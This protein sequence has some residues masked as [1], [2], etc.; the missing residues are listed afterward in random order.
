VKQEGGKREGVN[1]EAVA[2][3]VDGVDGCGAAKP[4]AAARALQVR[5]P[6][7]DAKP[8]K[9]SPS[10][11]AAG[12]AGAP[13]APAPASVAAA[14]AKTAS[15]AA[16]ATAA[17]GRGKQV[18]EQAPHSS[19][20]LEAARMPGVA[21]AAPPLPPQA[22]LLPAGASGRAD[23]A[24]AAAL[25]D[26]TSPVQPLPASA[27]VASR[28][29]VLLPGPVRFV[30]ASPQ[31]LV[32]FASATHP[33]QQ[34]PA[35]ANPLLLPH[36]EL[37]GPP[38][39]ADGASAGVLLAVQEAA[40]GAPTWPTSSAIA[41]VSGLSSEPVQ[42]G[43]NAAAQPG[44]LLQQQQQQQQKQAKGAQA[45]A[46][47][48]PR[49]A[50]A[51]AAA[52]GGTLR[53]AS[54]PFDGLDAALP[55]EQRAERAARRSAV[56]EMRLIAVEANRGLHQPGRNLAGTLVEAA[57]AVEEQEA[58]GALQDLPRLTINTGRGEPAA[59]AAAVAAA[60]PTA[61]ADPGLQVNGS[62]ASPFASPS[63]RSPGSARPAHRQRK[64]PV[65]ASPDPATSLPWAPDWHHSGKRQRT[66]SPLE[67]P[68]QAK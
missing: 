32:R 16:A 33:E 15:P 7:K 18:V 52:T 36:A 57:A 24:T 65:H 58:A 12:A 1:Q 37:L 23:S 19:Q 41:A 47:K 25:Q 64:R 14:A 66:G 21:A 61:A 59:A 39:A 56:A 68:Q 8:A 35:A 27:V 6:V 51:Q 42:T 38:A 55:A 63:P 50:A 53:T 28:V 10:K 3:A 22:S 20:Q 46:A 44:K 49:R 11:R 67:L 60:S 34:A 29:D 13:T 5:T 9:S 45:P 17:A 26:S 2:V 31:K 48:R 30:A 62:H 43:V 54:S 4:G 40:S